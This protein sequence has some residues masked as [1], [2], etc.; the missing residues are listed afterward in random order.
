M[1]DNGKPVFV[2]YKPEEI[3]DLANMISCWQELA[4]SNGL[5]GICF[6][7]TLRNATS[8]KASS[9]QFDKTI[10]FEPF[11]SL[12]KNKKIGAPYR[13]DWLRKLVPFAYERLRTSLRIILIFMR[14][15]HLLTIDYDKVWRE[16]TIDEE[17]SSTQALGAF[18]D[19]D[20]SPRRKVEGTIFR[21]A[22]PDKFEKYFKK[23]IEKANRNNVGYI[24][25]SAWNEW[26]E[27]T[28]LEPDMKYGHGYLMALAKAKSNAECKL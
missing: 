21:G 10:R 11:Y 23:L 28:Y 12:S 6:F 25:I 13:M 24:F 7:A 14:M 15:G 27:G 16:I 5:N 2:I 9:A 19:W 22:N 26:A 18:V 8:W 1:R 20:N 3:P 17:I 4:L